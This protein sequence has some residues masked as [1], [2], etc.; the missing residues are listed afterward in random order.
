MR[1]LF[2]IF[3]FAPLALL[4]QSHG[5]RWWTHV[6]ALANDGMEGR[7]TGSPAHKRAADYVAT[8]F[9]KAGLEPA[10][11]AGYI[12]PIQFNARRLLEAQS[13]L[14]LIRNGKTEPLVLG[15]DANISV[16]ADPA[17]SL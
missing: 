6:Q 14:A 1:R 12:Q 16:R 2:A 15:E 9:Q 11:L 4:A 17:A 10:G 5:S 13:S 7:N 8:Q 3:L